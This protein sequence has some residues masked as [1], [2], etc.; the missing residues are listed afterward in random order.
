[1]RPSAERYLDSSCLVRSTSVQV[2]LGYL[3]SIDVELEVIISSNID[4]EETGCGN[5]NRPPEIAGSIGCRAGIWS[6]PNPL[7]ALRLLRPL[8]DSIPPP[9]VDVNRAIDNRVDPVTGK[10]R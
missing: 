8:L 7:S 6:S 1:M 9:G 5:V 4:G 10:N 2:T 3:L